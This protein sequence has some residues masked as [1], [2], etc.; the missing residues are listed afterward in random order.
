MF[1]KTAVLNLMFSC[2]ATAVIKSNFIEC[3]FECTVAKRRDLAM[4]KKKLWNHK[5]I[6]V[7]HGNYPYIFTHKTKYRFLPKYIFSK[8]Q[9]VACTD[10]P[11]HVCF[12]LLSL[13][14]FPHSK[15]NTAQIACNKEMFSTMHLANSQEGLVQMGEGCGRSQKLWA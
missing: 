10:L 3:P 5:Y 12:S 15:R 1:V 9:I 2:N 11:F 13:Q 6:L 7:P 4:W 14:C 8:Y